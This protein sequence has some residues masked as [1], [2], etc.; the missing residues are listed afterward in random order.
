LSKSS[1]SNNYDVVVI[2]SGVAGALVAR[3]LADAGRR[4]CVL[5]AGDSW[6][7]DT[8]LTRYQSSWNRTLTAP[9]KQAAWA[10]TSADSEYFAGEG[11]QQYQ[12]SF[13]KGVGGTTW[14]WTGIT[15][16]F[17]PSDFKLRSNYGVGVDWPIRYEDLEPYYVQAEVALGVAGDSLDTHGSPRSQAYPMQAI[18]MTYG[19][20]RIAK[21]LLPFGIRTAS[22]P[23]ARNS[24]AYDGRPA[25]RGNNSC[26]PLCPIGA[27]YSGD[28]DIKK[29]ISAGARVIKQATVYSLDV[30]EGNK[31]SKAHYKHPDGSEHSVSADRFVIAC[32][33][34][35]TPR[36][37]LMSANRANNHSIA[38]GS[39]QVGKNLMDHAIIT[40]KFNMD[41]PLYIGRGPQSVS[42]LLIGRDGDFR[43]KYAAAKFFLGND[44]N[45]HQETAQMLQQPDQWIEPLKKLKN[46]AIYQ[47]Q[48]GAEIEQLP[49]QR[50]RLIVN[51]KRVDP[52]GLPLPVIDYTLSDYTQK[53]VEIWT[54]YIHDIVR[55]LDAKMIDL[56]VS[57]SSHHP[58]GTTRMGVDPH[59]SVVNSQCQSHDHQNLYI[60]GGS[61]FPSIGTA[62][63]TL[64]IAALSL[65]LANHILSK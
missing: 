32:N 62:N 29:A 19:D 9:F 37:L 17:L 55:K 26:T 57:L 16:R 54:E 27:S 64:T 11:N 36:L 47:G 18:P 63:P 31:I 20:R 52:L 61:V 40:S 41:E 30:D 51:H 39:G 3:K 21:K 35:E 15:P 46:I 59:D 8:A 65:R 58:T 1:S 53:G 34:I 45:I 23:A 12:P 42:T 25:C 14:H 10:Y 7:R 22:L 13:L 49:N 43:R 5:E 48:L 6:Q 4:V 50:N 56:S 28:I 2:G 33:S 38:N 60:V 44:L 24:E